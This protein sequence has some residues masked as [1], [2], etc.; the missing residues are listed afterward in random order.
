MHP[1]L[2]S[3]YTPLVAGIQPCT[4]HLQPSK[5]IHHRPGP[6]YCRLSVKTLFRSKGFLPIPAFSKHCPSPL[7]Q[8]FPHPF[9]FMPSHAHAQTTSSG[10]RCLDNVTVIL[11]RDF[12][13][14]T[15]TCYRYL[16]I[17]PLGI[18]PLIKKPF[19]VDG[20]P[21]LRD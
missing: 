16:Q 15:T 6:H 2:H 12:P 19:C 17:N 18:K 9:Q 4:P 3:L 1:P 10:Q 7:R 21:K 13:G 5:E 14:Y 8:C 20:R 11:Y